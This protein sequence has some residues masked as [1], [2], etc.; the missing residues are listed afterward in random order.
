LLEGVWPDIFEDEGILTVH[1][2][3]LRKAFGD[4]KQS[5]VY[6]ET[7]SRSGYRF[8]AT[9]TQA[10]ASDAATTEPLVWLAREVQR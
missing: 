2:A 7:V 5:P 3:A 8:I 10:S 6:I 4:R 1:V 9:V